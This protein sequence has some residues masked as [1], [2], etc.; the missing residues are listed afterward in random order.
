MCVYIHK[1]YGL[2]ELEDCSSACWETCPK[3]SFHTCFL[4]NPALRSMMLDSGKPPVARPPYFQ[5]PFAKIETETFGL[6]IAASW[7]TKCRQH[8]LRNAD[9]PHTYSP[10]VHSHLQS[11]EVQT[12]QLEILWP[13][14][15]FT[16]RVRN[17]D[18]SL[19]YAE[20]INIR[21]A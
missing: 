4:Y 20:L 17:A 6:R 12:V 19:A 15:G 21:K 5:V 10:S 11:V 9:S 13:S 2:E 3:R 8:G 1:S 14:V 7:V 16:V 18:G